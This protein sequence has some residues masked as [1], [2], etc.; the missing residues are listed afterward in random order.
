MMENL[1]Y[2][3][4]DFFDRQENSS[5]ALTSKLTSHPDA[6]QNTIS[7]NLF[8]ILIVIV[9]VIATTCLAIAY[10]W[11][12]GLVVVFGGLPVLIGC[13]SIRIRLESKFQMETD[14]RFAESAAIAN[15]AVTS[16]RTVASLTLEEDVF[17]QYAEIVDK[18]VASSTRSFLSGMIA[19]SLAQSL[20]FLVMALGFGSR[21]LADGEYTVS[22]F[23]VIFIAVV[24]GG[25]A[26]GQ[27]F[28]FSTS[29]SKAKSAA[30]YIL[31]LRTLK[32]DISEDRTNEAIGPQG[33]GPLHLEHVEFQYR[34]R[35]SARVL[36]GIDMKVSFGDFWIGWYELITDTNSVG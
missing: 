29:I 12:L 32:A 35:D 33:D 10:G 20:E 2:L 15:E 23:Y 17:G 1:I 14:E 34:Q 8:L 28:G 22:Q 3:D 19:Y 5:G 36:K 21:L 7:I 27:F 18:I 9:N 4:Q 30:N 6:L 13:G 31:W 25:Q 24:F 26:A 11:K 16:I